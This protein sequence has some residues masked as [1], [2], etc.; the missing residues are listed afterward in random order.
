MENLD[1]EEDMKEWGIR[2]NRGIGRRENINNSIKVNWQ[3]NKGLE[4]VKE[5]KKNN[6]LWKGRGRG[7]KKYIMIET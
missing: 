2:M 7:E 5:Y 3:S 1:L 6:S 4:K